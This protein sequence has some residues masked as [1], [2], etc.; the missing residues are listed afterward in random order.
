V[1]EAREATVTAHNLGSG[2]FNNRVAYLLTVAGG[3]QK[4]L[5]TTTCWPWLASVHQSMKER[6]AITESDGLDLIE[7]KEIMEWR[8][9][10][11][12]LPRRLRDTSNQSCK[13]DA[14]AT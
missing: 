1:R 12:W 2:H 10:I 14:C 11:D 8:P 3:S 7:L 6:N 9:L 4:V 13:A 5:T